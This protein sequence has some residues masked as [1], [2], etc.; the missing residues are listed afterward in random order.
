MKT[1]YSGKIDRVVWQN[2]SNVLMHFQI[3]LSTSLWKQNCEFFRMYFIVRFQNEFNSF[4]AN[5]YVQFTEYSSMSYTSRQVTDLLEALA[6]QFC[7][8]PILCFCKQKILGVA[9]MNLYLRNE[10]INPGKVT[11]YIKHRC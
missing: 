4:S 10:L 6:K 7:I 1:R 11:R 3:I 8:H 9:H 2:F 5:I